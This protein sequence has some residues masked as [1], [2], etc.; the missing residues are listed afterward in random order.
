[1]AGITAVRSVRQAVRQLKRMDY[2]GE[3]W[4]SIREASRSAIKRVLEDHM[5]R[6]RRRYLAEI[7]A[8]GIDDRCNGYY[9]RQLLTRMG[10]I[11]LSIPRTR[12]FS[13]V[14][15]LRAY[16]RREDCVDR[17]ILAC[18]VFGLSTRKVGTALLPILG[19]R[20]SAST[21]SQIAK[22]LD[23]AVAAFHRRPLTDK[24][25]ILVLDGV[26]LARKTGAGAIR[27]PVLVAMGITPDQKREI[28]DFSMA[29]SES[30]KDW[31]GFLTDLYNRGLTGRHL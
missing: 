7:D 10:S 1:M 13:A 31:E 12:T 2:Q 4:D 3:G 20:V 6:I 23:E 8:Q 26:V 19:E 14:K 11:E 9:P 28:L 25:K 29:R 22:T 27:R 5:E 24:Y 17:M 18:F 15:A 30:E 16:A 21:V